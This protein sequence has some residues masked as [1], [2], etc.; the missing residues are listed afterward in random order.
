MRE[1]QWVG[2]D[3]CKKYLDVYVRPLDKL[4][5]VPNNQEGID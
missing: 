4:F 1:E 5:Q 3:V 2:I